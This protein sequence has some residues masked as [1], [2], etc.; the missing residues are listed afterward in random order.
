MQIL[1]HSISGTWASLDFGTPEKSWD[2]SPM[3]TKGQMY[4]WNDWLTEWMNE[5]LLS[6]SALAITLSQHSQHWSQDIFF[7]QKKLANLSLLFKIL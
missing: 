4:L 7:P 6:Y 1:H 2:Q 3:D 5:L